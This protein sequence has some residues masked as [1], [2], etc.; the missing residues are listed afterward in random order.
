MES[1]LNMRTICDATCNWYVRIRSHYNVVTNAN[2][3][4]SRRIKLLSSY[5]QCVVEFFVNEGEI[6]L[7]DVWSWR[8][9]SKIIFFVRD[10]PCKL[11]LFTSVQAIH[12]KRWMYTIEEDIVDDI[13]VR[14]SR[15]IPTHLK[16]FLSMN[17]IHFE[18]YK[19]KE[20][21]CLWKLELQ[22][23]CNLNNN[24]Q[25][26]IRITYLHIFKAYPLS[27]KAPK[28]R[29]RLVYW[30]QFNMP[31]SWPCDYFVPP[32]SIRIWINAVFGFF[33]LP[34]NMIMIVNSNF[35]WRFVRKIII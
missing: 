9:F 21:K 23:C 24:V 19:F 2:V 16:H 22:L 6:T 12:S 15:T 35:Y 4:R 31:R 3:W 13:F 25:W 18:F 29:F 11:M 28:H 26:S 32:Q 33:F 27:P 7:L 5:V 8:W 20:I 30:F 17:K 1:A 34:P 10:R 14:N